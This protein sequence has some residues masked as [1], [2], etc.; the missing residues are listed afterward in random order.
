MV[1]NR[2]ILLSA[3]RIEPYKQLLRQTATKLESPNTTLQDAEVILEKAVE[4]KLSKGRSIRMIVASSL[5][6]AS[7]RA[8]TG[9]VQDEVAAAVST[10]KKPTTV[11]EISNTIRSMAQ[12]LAIGPEYLFSKPSSYIHR[13]L[14]RL[15]AQDK[16]LENKALALVSSLSMRHL[17]GC[18]PLS[19]AGASIYI[20]G[21]ETGLAQ[22]EI[23]RG[24]FVSEVTIRSVT[25]R[26]REQR[27]LRTLN[28][29][30]A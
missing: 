19:I 20:V 10:K 27:A 26:I 29:R 5:I 8:G 1:R 30:W 23:A 28:E 2:H 21:K 13:I 17:S 14:H 15:G 11:G 12:K 22:S 4:R 16:E 7:N 6:L 25:K 9:L 18:N 3:L 24:S